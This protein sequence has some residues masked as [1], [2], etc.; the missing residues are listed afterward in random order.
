MGQK[1]VQP[2]LTSFEEN[3]GAPEENESW[4]TI[5]TI[6]TYLAVDLSSCDKDCSAKRKVCHYYGCE[7]TNSIYTHTMTGIAMRKC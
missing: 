5:F 4:V 3:K 1:K 7:H 2:P 6:Y